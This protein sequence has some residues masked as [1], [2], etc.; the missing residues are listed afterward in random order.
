LS[1]ECS[2]AGTTKGRR[3]ATYAHTAIGHLRGNAETKTLLRFVRIE[4]F[5]FLPETVEIRIVG[6]TKHFQAPR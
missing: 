6:S 5:D 4:P 3:T 1:Y 2:G